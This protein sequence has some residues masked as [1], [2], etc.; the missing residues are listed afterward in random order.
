MV[1]RDADG[2]EKNALR[3][4]HARRKEC[5]CFQVE[6]GVA[7]RGCEGEIWRKTDYT[8][9]AEPVGRGQGME[10]PHQTIGRKDTANHQLQQFKKT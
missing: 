4:S 1:G 10:L 6:G 7:R 5:N 9:D 2:R 3:E 8:M